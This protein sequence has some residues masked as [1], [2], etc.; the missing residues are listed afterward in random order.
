MAVTL[1]QPSVAVI[2]ICMLSFPHDPV[3]FLYEGCRKKST[4]E[5]EPDKIWLIRKAEKLS[6]S[7]WILLFIVFLAAVWI[8][9][10]TLEHFG[11][12]FPFEGRENTVK[13]L[14]KW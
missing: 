8:L 3:I 7:Q 2:Y 5:A 10:V 13:K 4:D 1:E 12:T 6:I 14:P 11:I 9:N